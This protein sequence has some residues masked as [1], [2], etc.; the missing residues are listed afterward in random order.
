MYLW[1]QI[2]P[3]DYEFAH[4]IAESFFK[5]K[6]KK[7]NLNPNEFIDASEKPDIITRDVEQFIFNWNGMDGKTCYSVIINRRHPFEQ[8]FNNFTKPEKSLE[9][10]P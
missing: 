9:D 5:E 1:D 3:T 10:C 2:F 8:Q 4:Y 6:I 7:Y